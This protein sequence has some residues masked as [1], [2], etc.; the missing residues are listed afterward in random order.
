MSTLASVLTAAGE[1]AGAENLEIVRGGVAGKGKVL[2]SLTQD[3][4]DDRGRQS[5]AAE[6]TD[7]EVIAVVN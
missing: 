7:R 6:A 3:F 1:V 4:V 2:F 5:I